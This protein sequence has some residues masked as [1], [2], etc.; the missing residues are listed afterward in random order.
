MLQIRKIEIEDFSR[1]NSLL[2]TIE[3]DQ[4]LGFIAI[5]GNDL[6]KKC[7]SKYIALGIQS[8]FQGKKLEAY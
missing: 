6:I 4:L 7:H 2:K 8:E 5:L 3:S 1:F